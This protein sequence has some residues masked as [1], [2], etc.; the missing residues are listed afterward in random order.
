METNRAITHY[1][2]SF[3]KISSTGRR[4]KMLK[5]EQL[6]FITQ[7]FYCSTT[8]Y[9]KTRLTRIKCSAVSSSIVTHFDY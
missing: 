6:F 4:K 5:K 9:S 3:Q 1:I 7:L 2:E 8:Y